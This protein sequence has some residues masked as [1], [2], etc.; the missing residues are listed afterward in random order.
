MKTVCVLLFLAGMALEAF[1]W[2]GLN[3][4]P[5]RRTFDEMAGMI[6]LAGVP[7]GLVLLFLAAILGWRH[8]GKPS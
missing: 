8:R 2:W 3:T 1:A 4:G 6:P 5:G 7:A